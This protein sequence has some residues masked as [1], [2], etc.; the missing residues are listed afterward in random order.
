MLTTLTLHRL[1]VF[2]HHGVLPEEKEKGTTF[3]ISLEIVYDAEKAIAGD[4]LRE[5]INYAAVCADTQLL[6]QS[7]RFNLIETL[8]HRIGTELMKKYSMIEII[9]VSV[10]KLRL[11]IPEKTDGATASVTFNQKKSD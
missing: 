1:S 5:A 4:D 11:P 2:A 7:T 3:E 10:H 8:A 6:T 9:T